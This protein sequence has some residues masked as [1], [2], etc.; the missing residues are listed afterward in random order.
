MTE[1][2]KEI[3]SNTAAVADA[4]SDDEVGEIAQTGEGEASKKKRKSK[5]KKVKDALTVGPTVNASVS[6]PTKASVTEAQ[7]QQLLSMNPSLK[8]EVADM[9]PAKI[10]ELMKNMDLSTAL[11]GMVRSAGL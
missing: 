5:S 7:F 4:N 11:S 9:D 8:N 6:D 3:D 1:E 2:S 10:E